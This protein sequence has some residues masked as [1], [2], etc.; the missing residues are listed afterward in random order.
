MSRDTGTRVLAQKP[1][2]ASPAQAGD[3][4]RRL[5][6]ELTR[7]RQRRTEATLLARL[8]ETA[9]REAERELSTLSVRLRDTESEAARL[10]DELGAARDRPVPADSSTELEALRAERDAL[11]RK[12]EEIAHER[13]LDAFSAWLLQPRVAL[14]LLRRRRAKAEAAVLRA[15]EA[16]GLFPA[17][18]P[19][20]IARLAEPRT[21]LALQGRRLVSGWGRT[22]QGVRFRLNAVS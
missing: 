6:L 8:S 20:S 4:L 19:S 1:P 12:L 10:R 7:E 9:A 17:V 13:R 14:G 11:V 21:V 18:P 22:V 16:Q 5:E 3:E 15:A 2:E